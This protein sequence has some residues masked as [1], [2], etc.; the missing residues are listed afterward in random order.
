MTHLLSRVADVSY[1]RRGRLVLAWI[2]ATAV[3][4]GVGS[5]LAGEY[6]ADYNTPGSSPRPRASSRRSASAALRERGLR[7]L[8]GPAR[9]AG[10]AAARTRVDAFLP[11]ARKVDDVAKEIP[12]RI[13]RDDTIGSTT[14]PL[15]IDSWDVPNA[16]G[17]HEL[18]LAE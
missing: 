3:I 16:D 10:G 12:I 6:N 1:R 4:I 8:E 9:K 2:A 13:S 5:A 17:H 14:L 7:R 11:E 18:D 15:T